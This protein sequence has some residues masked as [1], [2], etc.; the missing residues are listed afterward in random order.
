MGSHKSNQ[1]KLFIK[2]LIFLFFKQ[3]MEKDPSKFLEIL[4]TF[5]GITLGYKCNHELKEEF[6]INSGDE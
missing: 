1:K 6:K 5:D 3:N 2:N 4:N